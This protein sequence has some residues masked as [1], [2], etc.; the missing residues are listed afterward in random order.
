MSQ[1]GHK[2][3]FHVRKSFALMLLCGATLVPSRM[4]AQLFVPTYA[5]AQSADTAP[6]CPTDNAADSYAYQTGLIVYH[7]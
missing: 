1:R 2:R 3:L 7:K 5:I 6:S 4:A